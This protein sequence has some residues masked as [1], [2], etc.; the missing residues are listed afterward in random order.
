MAKKD[1]LSTDDVYLSYVWERVANSLMMSHD[2]GVL[3][4]NSDLVPYEFPQS[5]KFLN[6]IYQTLS[7]PRVYDK[8]V[9]FF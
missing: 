4:I 5:C 3:S 9:N 6:I 8:I 2:A 1:N 7:P